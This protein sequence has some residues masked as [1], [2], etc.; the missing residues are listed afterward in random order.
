VIASHELV[1]KLIAFFFSTDFQLLFWGTSTT[2]TFVYTLGLFLDSYHLSDIERSDR[3]WRLIT[4]G[5]IC[6]YWAINASMWFASTTKWM[7]ISDSFFL[8]LGLIVYR[9]LQFRW[10]ALLSML[11]FG[12]VGLDI[13]LWRG[14]DQ[15]EYAILSNIIFAIQLLCVAGFKGEILRRAWRVVKSRSFSPFRRRQRDQGSHY[16]YHATD[17]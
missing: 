2:V 12:S 16:R 9:K 3:Q 6:V 5:L 15:M 8:F 10:A 14:M 11:F 17:S 1:S 7:L 13:C 4:A